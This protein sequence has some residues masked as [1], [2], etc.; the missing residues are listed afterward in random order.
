MLHEP[1]LSSARASELAKLA[2]YLQQ[3]REQERGD[4]ARELHDEL[5]ALLTCAKL[6]IASLK[7][8]LAGSSSEINQRLQHLSETVNSGIAFSRRV[9][10]GLHPS[11]LT[12]LGLKS[13]LDILTREFG[14][15]TGVRMSVMMDDVKLDEAS[16][17]AAYRI[18]QESLNNVAKSAAA[19]Q[20]WVTMFDCDSD[21]VMS[22]RDNGKGFDAAAMGAGSHGLAGMRHRAESCG[23]QLHVSSR[24]GSGTLIVAVLPMRA[25]AAALP[26]SEP[27]DPTCPSSYRPAPIDFA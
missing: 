9:V 5:G 10:E 4:L 11:S 14:A 16:A 3:A 25:R 1:S 17:L 2:T 15:N 13:S 8:R 24:P 27:D 19:K 21:V 26:F 6:D 20:A 12:N 22:V 7:S 18:V 23:G